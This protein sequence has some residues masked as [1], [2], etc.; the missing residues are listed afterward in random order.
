[1]TDIEGVV[2]GFK[3]VLRG[4]RIEDAEDDY[5][6]RTDPELALIDATSPIRISLSEFERMLRDELRHP[7]SWVRRY[8]IDTLEG[9]HI[10]NCMLYD[11]DTVNGEAELG[12][13]VGE[14]EYWGR[15]YG[16]EA[17]AYL[18]EESF[19]ISSM[20]RLRLHTLAWN[21]RARSAFS[22]V[23]FRELREVRR[24]NKD[25]IRMQITR[26]EWEAVR[27]EVLEPPLD[28]AGA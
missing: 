4:K 25:F 11:L 15:G 22:K 5:R 27:D 13:M 20:R 14:R 18:V 7:T 3:V 28:A 2:R 8:G 19:K 17:M 21:A 12:I 23:G 24:S 1:M 9:Q 16:R 26:E 6:W 10:G